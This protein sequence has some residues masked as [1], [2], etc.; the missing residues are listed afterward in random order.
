MKAS[1]LKD[2]SV[3]DLKEKITEKS[4][5]LAK[6]KMS[7]AISPVENPMNIRSTRKHVARLKTELS[8]RNKAAAK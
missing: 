6:L 4:A 1:E 3:E 5:E 8:K 2:L 7:H